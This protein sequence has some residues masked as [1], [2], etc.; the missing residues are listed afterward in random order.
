[1]L[2]CGM[3]PGFNAYKI[4]FLFKQICIVL[5]LIVSSFVDMRQHTLLVCLVKS[6]IQNDL[7]QYHIHYFAP[8]TKHHVWDN[9]L[10]EFAT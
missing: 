8:S 4:Q 9:N 7:L 5:K 1:M 3:M 2:K 6:S 10:Y